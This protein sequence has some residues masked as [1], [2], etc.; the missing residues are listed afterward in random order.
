MIV[1]A[2]WNSASQRAAAVAMATEAHAELHEVR[3]VVDAIDRPALLAELAGLGL[4]PVVD[5]GGPVRVAYDGPTAQSVIARLTT[6]LTVLRVHD[7]SLEE[8]YVALLRET[9]DADSTGAVAA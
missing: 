7:P 4:A 2:S 9:A 6:P 1:D 8:A 3:C 5:D